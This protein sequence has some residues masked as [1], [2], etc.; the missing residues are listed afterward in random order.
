MCQSQPSRIVQMQFFSTSTA[1]SSVKSLLAV[2][3]PNKLVDM[4]KKKVY[5]YFRSGLVQQ[6]HHLL[7]KRYVPPCTEEMQIIQFQ[8]SPE[9]PTT[10]PRVPTENPNNQTIQPKITKF[11]STALHIIPNR[12]TK[13]YPYIITPIIIMSNTFYPLPFRTFIS[14]QPTCPKQFSRSICAPYLQ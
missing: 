3:Q 5:C 2:F 8:K 13:W 12:F 4:C 9:K 6:A 1:S 14:S 10:F 11:P 7:H